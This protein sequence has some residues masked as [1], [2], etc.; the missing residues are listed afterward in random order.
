MMML[1]EV[2]QAVGGVLRGSDVLIKS[3]GTDSRSIAKDQLF[4]GI[5]GERF[6]GNAYAMQA[7][8]QGAAGALVE[9]SD[10][11]IQ[12]AVIVQDA[13][14]SLGKLAHYW[15]G[16]FAIPLVAVTG[17]NGKTTVKEMIT[18]IL[19]AANAKVLATRGNLNNDIGMPLTLLGLRENHTHAVIE[20]G[21]NHEGE[22]RYL[23]GLAA[24]T[25]AVISNAGTAHI[26]E[27]GSR[28][29]IARA[30]GEVFEGLNQ[31][32]TAVINLDDD[33]A[34]YWQSLNTNRTVIT[35]GLDTQADIS[36]TY[37]LL[38]DG[39][40]AALKTPTGEVAFRLKVLGL[41]NIR[42]ALAASAVAHALGVSNEDIARGLQTFGAVK[43]RLNWLQGLNEAVVIDDTYNANPDSMRAAIE[44]LASQ[45]GSRIFVMGD[46]AELGEVAA[47]MHAEIGRYALEKGIDRMATF[48]ELS[49]YA[50]QA[51]GKQAQHF[52]TLEALLQSLKL[53]MHAGITVLVKGSRF[54]KM[55]RVVNEI[56]KA[57]LVMEAH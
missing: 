18:A 20:M 33:F 31:R 44:V 55:E 37:R 22:I 57:R 30:K 23:T 36:A 42:N 43:G 11:R 2:A 7:I 5:K 19:S 9:S 13:R 28:E 16:K 38:D 10:N 8:E 45:S 40:Q 49:R 17:S 35:F 21:M 52:D 53:T 50:S 29:A 14:L 54:M 47:S 6:D 27:L 56:V 39:A 1:S 25:V 51:F 48:G 24:P 4:V 41:H 32:G 34:S 26:G 3:V 12:P 46:M 15:R